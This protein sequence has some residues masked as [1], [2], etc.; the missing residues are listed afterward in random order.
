MVIL[1]GSS[2]QLGSIQTNT[3][4]ITWYLG[5]LL[6]TKLP[7]VRSLNTLGG[8]DRGA[9]KSRRWPDAITDT[10]FGKHFGNLGEFVEW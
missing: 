6:A 10:R 8:K 9:S 5:V 3:H 1:W 2:A 7:R 4:G